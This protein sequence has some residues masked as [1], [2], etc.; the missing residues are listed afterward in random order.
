MNGYPK[1]TPVWIK[2]TIK[3][4]EQEVEYWKG[5]VR[6]VTE[7]ESEVGYDWYGHLRTNGKRQYLPRGTEVFFKINNMADPIRVRVDRFGAL[8]IS[9]NRTLK[10]NPRACN[11]IH[12]GLEEE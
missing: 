4:L 6:S 11:V 9:G 5:K 10:V 2:D 7:E 12:V 8:Q 3:R 1:S